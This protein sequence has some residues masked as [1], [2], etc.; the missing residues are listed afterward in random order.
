MKLNSLTREILFVTTT[1]FSQR[2]FCEKDLQDKSSHLSPAEQLEAACWNG[3]LDEV[4]PEIM[5]DSP[6]GEKIYLCQVEMRS[7][8]LKLSLG[9]SSPDFETQFTI[10]AAIFIYQKEMN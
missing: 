8:C 6:C 7:S 9:A 10:D 3:I 5:Q 1:S 2:Q 4:L